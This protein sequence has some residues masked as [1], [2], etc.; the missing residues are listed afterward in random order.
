[1]TKNKWKLSTVCNVLF[2]EK[3][4]AE[5]EKSDKHQLF[6]VKLLNTFSV[7]EMFPASRRMAK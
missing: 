4:E 3:G 2:L 1:M 5:W 7:D 6:F